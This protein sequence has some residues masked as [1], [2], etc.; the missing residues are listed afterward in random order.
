MSN[1]FNKIFFAINMVWVLSDIFFTI[2]NHAKEDAPLRQDRGTL[3]WINIAIYLSMPL[4]VWLSMQRIGR[5][6]PE[7]LWVRWMGLALIIGGLVIKWG[8]VFQLKKQFTVDIAIVSGHRLVC[9]GLYSRLRHPSYFGALMAFAGLGVAL[10]NACS[11]AALLAPITLAFLFRI[12]VEEIILS[13][14][15]PDKYPAYRRSSWAL[16]PFIY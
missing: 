7:M 6:P 5:F 11:I 12:H 9:D 15:F 3:R 16:I 10:G 1:Q 13:K 4:A 2:F 14:A 8:A